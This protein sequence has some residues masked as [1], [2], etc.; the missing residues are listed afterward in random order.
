MRAV[1]QCRQ[2]WSSV[3]VEGRRKGGEVSGQRREVFEK[4]S[5]NKG[6]GRGKVREGL[7]MNSKRAASMVLYKDGEQRVYTG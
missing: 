1:P 6:R 2:R 7:R 5:T 3:A 4:E